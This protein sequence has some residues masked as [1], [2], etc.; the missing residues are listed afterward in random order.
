FD[1]DPSSKDVGYGLQR[2]I[3]SL[4]CEGYD[5]LAVFMPHMRPGDCTGHHDEMFNIKTTGS[6][7]KFFLETAALGLNYLETHSKADHFPKYRTFHMT[8]LSGGGWT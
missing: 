1:D 7:I 2:T 6:P 3:N 5:V 8:G 4:L